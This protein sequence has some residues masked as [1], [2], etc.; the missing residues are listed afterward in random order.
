MHSQYSKKIAI[1]RQPGMLNFRETTIVGYAGVH[2]F[3]TLA[4]V[5]PSF[6]GFVI[7]ALNIYS[8]ASIALTILQ[9]S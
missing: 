1:N 3:C 9:S 8:A 4:Q 6:R 5:E 7:L 2:H